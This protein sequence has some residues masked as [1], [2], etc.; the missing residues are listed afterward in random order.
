MIGRRVSVAG[1]GL[2]FE[3]T[4]AGLADDGALV[5][6]R[7]DGTRSEIRAADVRLLRELE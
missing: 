4:A 7:Q 2:D 6:E 5:V 3:A 1:P